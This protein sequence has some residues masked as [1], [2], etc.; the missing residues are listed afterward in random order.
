M[1]EYLTEFDLKANKLTKDQQEHLDL[2]LNTIA[3]ATAKYAVMSAKDLQ[4]LNEK[5]EKLK[6]ISGQ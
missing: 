2:Y 6:E 1:E 3:G 5:N 4:D